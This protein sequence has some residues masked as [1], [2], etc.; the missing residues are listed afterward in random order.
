M[1]SIAGKPAADVGVQVWNPDNPDDEVLAMVCRTGLNTVMGVMIKELLAPIR[2]YKEKDP[3][4]P[5]SCASL[6][7]FGQICMCHISQ[8]SCRPIQQ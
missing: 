2:Q 6:L 5:V 7:Q 1:V 8:Q 4:L 3:L